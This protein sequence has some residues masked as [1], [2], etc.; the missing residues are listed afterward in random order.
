M[1]SQ[2]QLVSYQRGGVVPS[3]SPYLPVSASTQLVSI[4]EWLSSVLILVMGVNS[5]VLTWVH[6]PLMGRG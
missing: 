1:I 3:S 4:Q 6:A 5:G 2:K